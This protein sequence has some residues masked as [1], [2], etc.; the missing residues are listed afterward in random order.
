MTADILRKLRDELSAGIYTEVQVVYLMVGTRKLIEREKLEDK[1]PSLKFHCDWALHCS[2]D[3]AA[4]KAILKQFD[5]AHEL[6][7][8]N[9]ELQNLP[10]KLRAE[11][12]RISTMSSFEQELSDFLA[13]YRL[14]QLTQHRTDGWVRFL[15]LYTQVI[16]DIPL[17]VSAP[18]SKKT[19]QLPASN[20]PPRHI[21][22]V[23]VHVEFAQ[24]ALKYAGRE[25]LLFK[26]TWRIHDKNGESGE[27]FILN[28]FSLQP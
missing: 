2:M 22:H 5:A 16:E 1:Y 3:R 28:S 13:A 27:I 9:V 21:S 24:Q 25:D 19:A 14:P 18:S 4:A 15:Q 23:T 7:R 26:I 6:L 10:S 17:V 8:G 20:T 11:I 12:D